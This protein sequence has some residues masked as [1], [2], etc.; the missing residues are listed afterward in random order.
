MFA[1]LCLIACQTTKSQSHQIT[2][3]VA[4]NET[5]VKKSIAIKG[6]IA[7]LAWD[8]L[9]PLT[10]MDNDG[11]YE[12]T[13][14]FDTNKKNVKYKFLIDGEEEF[15]GN[16]NRVLWYKSESQ[17]ANHTFNEY[18]YYDAKK[19]ASLT[20]SQ[21]EIKEDLIIL[22]NTLEYIHPNLNAYRNK[23][24][25]ENDYHKLESGI[26][27]NPTIPNAYKAISK[28]AS[29][30][31]CSHTFTNPWNQGTTIKS[32]I[33]YQPDK[34]PFSF[35][36]IGKQI[37]IDKNA[38]EKLELKNG[39]E[40]LKINGLNTDSILTRLVE[41]I[42]SDGDNY[43]KKLERLVLNG[44]EK[45]ALFDIFYSLEFGMQDSFVLELKD[46]QNGKI[47]TTDVKA[48]SKTKRS[49]ILNDRYADFAQSFKD[50]WKFEILDKEKAKLKIGSFAVF[51]KNFDWKDFL[52]DAFLQLKENSIKHLIIDIRE[53]EG[54]DP[55]VVEYL[56]ERIILEPLKIDPAKQTTAYKKIP[57][58]LRAHISTWDKKPYNW[59]LRVK[60]IGDK[61]Y[62]LRK[63]FT[64][65]SKTYTPNKNGFKGKTY[66]LIGA[67]NSSATH[68]MASYAK[69]YNLATLIGQT[70]GGNQR[71]Q[72]GGYIFFLKL[73]NS[74]IE[75]DIPV[76]GITTKTVT[77][78][79]TNGGITPNIIVEK[80]IPDLI[81]GMDTE[82]NTA[83]NFIQFSKKKLEKMKN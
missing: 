41:Y 13:I 66:L 31:K 60:K 19:I 9:H 8:K 57:D 55:E 50:S 51:N 52:N 23:E 49:K 12:T 79:T 10:D 77:P 48:I 40:V 42:T 70:T 83:L 75:V 59:G 64:E 46:H 27:A 65:Q 44:N 21:E 36:R 56:F 5:D 3:K 15:I 68:F 28:F 38:S 81:S 58:E 45:F 18:D 22:K 37:F 67:Q 73:P 7:P 16:D 47:F 76:I 14:R 33:F 24:A 17:I 63:L 29:K 25:L 69:R 39:L 71:G 35:S 78:S 80:N 2:F 32:A 72:N 6:S 62:Q 20:L 74:K 1:M 11:I 53:N 26:L 43:E 4:I 30:I 54:G 34:I 61:K 82:L